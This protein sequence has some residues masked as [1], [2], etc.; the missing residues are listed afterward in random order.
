MRS[1]L[2][3]IGVFLISEIC[4]ATCLPPKFDRRVVMGYENL[5]D[6]SSCSNEEIALLEGAYPIVIAQ[7]VRGR[8]MEQASLAIPTQL[9]NLKASLA[10]LKVEI[11]NRFGR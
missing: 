4:Q 3:V 2:A 5:Y 8:Q 10:L 11:R 1:L 6:F 9:A 7:V